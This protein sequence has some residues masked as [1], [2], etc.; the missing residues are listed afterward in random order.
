MSATSG[1]S[2]FWDTQDIIIEKEKN[3]REKIVV[4]KCTR[5]NKT[6]LDFRIH[7]KKDDSYVPTSKGINLEIDKAKELLQE[8][9]NIL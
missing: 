4:S 3:K 1:L 9:I 6:Y 5:Q 7:A 8:I 2:T